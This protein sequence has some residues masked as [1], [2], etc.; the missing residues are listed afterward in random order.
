[1]SFSIQKK[2]ID[3]VGNSKNGFSKCIIKSRIY[4]FHLKLLG[5]FMTLLTIGE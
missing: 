4:E 5:H 1:M 2:D 3:K